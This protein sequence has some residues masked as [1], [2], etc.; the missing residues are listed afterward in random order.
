MQIIEAGSPHEL[1]QIRTLFREYE[2]FLGID[3]EFQGFEQELARLPGAYS[4]PTGVLLLARDG[5]EILGCGALRP[6]GQPE[7]RTCEMKRLYVRPAARGLGLGRQIAEQLICR[8]VALGYS[9]MVLDTLDKLTAAIGLY[10]QLGF[11]RTEPYYHNP[12]PGVSYWKLDLDVSE[13]TIEAPQP[14]NA[15]GRKLAAPED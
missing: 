1:N 10:R 5:D 13:K 12:L 2:A 7:G 6:F 9:T 4:P 14:G 3:L 8:S 15:A 11:T